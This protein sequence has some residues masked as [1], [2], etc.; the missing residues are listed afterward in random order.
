MDLIEEVDG[1]K[2]YV[3]TFDDCNLIE[4]NNTNQNI[5]LN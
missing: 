4:D 3:I 5:E 1:L 2:Q